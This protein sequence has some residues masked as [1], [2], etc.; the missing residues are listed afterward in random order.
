MPKLV[1]FLVISAVAAMFVER[2]WHHHANSIPAGIAEKS[3]GQIRSVI[4]ADTLL[5]QRVTLLS[6]APVAVSAGR[7]SSDRFPDVVLTDHTGR[8]HRFRTDLIRDR[9]VCLAFFYSECQGSCPGTIA[10]MV[11]LRK[12]MSGE[13]AADRLT[14]I[15]LTLDPQTDTVEKLRRYAE[16]TGVRQDP[17]LGQWLF[18]TGTFD[19]LEEV[20][21]SLGLFD[22]DPVIDADRTQH[23]AL[24]TIGNDQ[25]DRWTALPSGLASA[26]L[27][28]TFLRIAGQSERQR[29]AVHL[30]KMG[31]HISTIVV[32]SSVY[33]PGTGTVNYGNTECC[34]K[35]SP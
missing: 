19:D 20:R 9:I 14:F 2:W 18:C 5:N 23:A 3:D 25:T 28:E 34:Q 24:I 31:Q 35:A 7:R 15:A 29:F 8:T 17:E 1:V 11:R 33:V 21:I 4:S 32:P 30:Q 27:H 13:F 26:D 16:Q 10:K 22:P 12:E 6:E